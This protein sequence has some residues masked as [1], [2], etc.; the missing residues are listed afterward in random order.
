MWQRI[1]LETGC[2]SK[3]GGRYKAVEVMTDCL[4]VASNINF[5][6]ISRD[7]LMQFMW[8]AKFIA[9][10]ASQVSVAALFA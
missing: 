8:F 7:T 3:W 10:Y 9:L 4:V 2:D 5:K 1:T 6:N